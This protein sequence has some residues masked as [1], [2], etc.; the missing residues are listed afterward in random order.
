MR[1]Q[2]KRA[3]GRQ[4]GLH[5]LVMANKFNR[6]PTNSADSSVAPDRTLESAFYL[7][8]IEEDLID[9]K[10]LL[11]CALGPLATAF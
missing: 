3:L 10:V 6:L 11:V 9:S 7:G 2:R 5:K 4:I 1:L 8:A